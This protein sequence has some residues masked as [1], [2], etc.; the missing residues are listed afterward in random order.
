MSLDE[1]SS[2]QQQQES[3]SAASPRVGEFDSAFSALG[4]TLIG[5][6]GDFWNPYQND[7]D[8]GSALNLFPLLEAGG[9]IDLAH[10]L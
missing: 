3:L 10:Y 6:D 7:G 8:S 4:D 2:P 9:G 1:S 5:Q